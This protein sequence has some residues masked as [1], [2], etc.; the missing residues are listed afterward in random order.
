MHALVV[1]RHRQQ[2]GTHS[3]ASGQQHVELARGR[4]RRDLTRQ[5]HQVICGVT[6][7]RDDDDD[8][9]ALLLRRDNPLGYPLDAVGV[10][11]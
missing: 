8:I 10:S 11:D 5:A 6:H 7:C 1:N 2:R 9:V 4:Q 3:L